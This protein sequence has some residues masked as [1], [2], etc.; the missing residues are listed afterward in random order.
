MG[1]PWGRASSGSSGRSDAPCGTRSSTT[2]CGLNISS[3]VA[4]LAANVFGKDEAAEDD[5]ASFFDFSS[6][7]MSLVLETSTEL[8]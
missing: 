4:M 1:A 7:H 5:A 8:L 2:S 6:H 3:F